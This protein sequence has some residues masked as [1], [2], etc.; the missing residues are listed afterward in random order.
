MS[1]TN[2]PNRRPG[3]PS[4]PRV[5][6]CGGA[7]P[8]ES[9]TRRRQMLHRWASRAIGTTR[10]A[11]GTATLRIVVAHPEPE[12]LAEVLQV[13]DHERDAEHEQRQHQRGLGDQVERDLAR[14][15][16]L[17]LLERLALVVVDAVR[18]RHVVERA[19][20]AS[21]GA[22]VG[23]RLSSMRLSRNEVIGS[24]EIT[25]SE[26]VITI[27]AA[28]PLAA[29]N[30]PS[31]SM[32]PLPSTEKT[33]ATELRSTLL[34]S[35]SGSGASARATLAIPTAAKTTET[36]N[37]MTIFCTGDRGDRL[38]EVVEGGQLAGAVAADR[39]VGV[40]RALEV[41]EPARDVLVEE[42]AQE[43]PQARHPH[44]ARHAPVAG[45]HGE[46]RREV[47]GDVERR[48]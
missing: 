39:G 11:H 14:R 45:A 10:H 28:A 6:T 37:Q 29:S 12:V 20:S 19:A 4:S 27:T 8:S 24:A 13:A 3:V 31:A 41:R 15:P 23:R 40:E 26:S 7:A 48:R 34:A 44:A 33:L 38:L 36:V 22:S 43:H 32:I 18:A 35:V 21:V 17:E 5:N 42:V 47:V 25:Y 16:H 1:T 9:A 46:Q 30:L 2:A